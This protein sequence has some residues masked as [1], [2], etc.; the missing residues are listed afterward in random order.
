MNRSELQEI[1]RIRINEAATLLRA[2][3]YAGAY[4]LA[5]YSVECALKVCIAK[6]TK[7]YDFPN[8]ELAIKVWVHDLEKLIKLAGLW[9]K[10]D[11]DMKTNKT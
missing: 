11:R 7:K 10:L 3:Q 2:G 8:K 1:S 5:G 4:Y 6:Q 9:P